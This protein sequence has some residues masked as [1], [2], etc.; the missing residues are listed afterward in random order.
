MFKCSYCE[1][2]FSVPETIRGSY[3]DDNGVSHLFQNKHYYTKSVCP[4]CGY[5]DFEEI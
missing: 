4:E 5:D 3:E 2:H 1:H